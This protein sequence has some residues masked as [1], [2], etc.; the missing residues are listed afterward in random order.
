[1]IATFMLGA[2][3]FIFVSNKKYKWNGMS[4][5]FQ[6]IGQEAIANNS[7]DS[8]LDTIDTDS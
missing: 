5:L 1:M 6:P 2:V 7:K 3:I 4:R 8:H